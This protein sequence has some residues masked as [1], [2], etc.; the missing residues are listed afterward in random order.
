MKSAFLALSLLAAAIP[1]QVTVIS[2][3]IPSPTNLDRPWP[4]G[5][6][7]YQQWYSAASLQGAILE[8]MRI[9][10]IEFFAGS[11][12]TSNAGQINCEIRM[13]HGLPSGL[14]GTFDSNWSGGP[15]AA[16]V[17][18]PAGNVQLTAATTGA[19]CLNIPFS[20][21]FTW[22]RSR[23]LLLEVRIF[24]NSFGS[25][26]FLY[27]MQGSVLSIG[28]TSRVYAGGTSGPVSGTVSQGWGLK[29]RFTARPGVTFTYGSG[30]PG[31]GGFIPT[32][33]VDAVPSPA[34]TWTHT[35]S[36]AASQRLAIWVLGT[37]TAPPFPLD[38][39]ELLGF[40]P[41]GC[42][43]RSDFPATV[44]AVT[45]GGGAGGGI[46]TVPMQLPATTG[47]VGWSLF[48]QWVV[49][50]PLA[51]NGILS[52]TAGTWSIVAPGGGA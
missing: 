11:S 33:S 26:P 52:T 44:A 19:V 17:V 48:S 43:L 15:T 30:C 3:N 32:A 35:L 31:E 9:E 24:G 36:N 23:P 49:F 51:A 14:T 47:Y 12:L 1:A 10:R 38:L 16:V 27:N 39:T 41:T 50:D 21:R 40:G 45:V 37:S 34:T 42:F 6:G 7:R 18:K 8:P 46:A 4:G 13:G 22:D 2:P 20:T 25:Q 28:T 29:T 5:L